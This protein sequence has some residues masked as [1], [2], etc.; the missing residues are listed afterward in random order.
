MTNNLIRNQFIRVAAVAI[1]FAV[2]PLS[3]AVIAPPGSQMTE[4]PALR[5]SLRTGDVIKQNDLTT[6]A[7]PAQQVGNNI[8]RDAE[9]LVGMAVT[10]A[11]AG[12]RP[13]RDSDIRQPILAKKGALVKMIVTTPHMVLSATGRA[14][15][16][17]SLGDNIRLI[18]TFTNKSV[19]GTVA[20]DGSIIIHAG[21]RLALAR[22]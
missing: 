4:V 12:N 5:L 11:M 1:S 9:S 2:S 16:N 7:I 18:N 13:I 10:H 22:N 17:G 14:M 3:A 8:I 21:N 6:T 15:E 19:E 20:A